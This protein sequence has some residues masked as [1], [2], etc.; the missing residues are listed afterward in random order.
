MKDILHCVPLSERAD[1]PRFW[2]ILDELIQAKKLPKSRKYEASKKK[3]KDIKEEKEIVET[4]KKKKGEPDENM[5]ALIRKI[6]GKQNN[7]DEFF[8]NLE[9]KYGKKTEKKTEKKTVKKTLKKRK[10]K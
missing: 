4:D 9:E 7:P 3:V 5:L 8:N 10:I 6:K 1:L 2:N